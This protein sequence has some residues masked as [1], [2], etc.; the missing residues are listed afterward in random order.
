MA[1]NNHKDSCGFDAA[2]GGPKLWWIGHATVLIRMGNRWILTDPLLRERLG[3]VFKRLAP[4]GIPLDRLPELDVV[5][6]SHAHMDH[7]DYWSLKQIKTSSAVLVT[8]KDM[9]WWPIHIK[10]QLS[11]RPWESVDCKGIRITWAPVKHWGGRWLFDRV[12]RRSYTG[13][14]LEYGGTAIFFA[15]D[16]GYTEKN[17]AEIAERFRI[18]VALLPVGPAG[19]PFFYK[20]FTWRSHTDP[21]QAMRIF[22]TLNARCM[23]PIHHG[24]FYW[25]GPDEISAINNAIRDHGLKDKVFLLAPGQE[26]D[27]AAMCA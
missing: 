16:T 15:G 19:T 13:Y 1:T 24:T 4:C 11:G 25:N 7:L 21:D 12:W 9:P 10:E 20:W 3:V 6:I 2:G 14:V 17:F 27:L 26:L 22:K 23:V 5:L 8:P 18:D